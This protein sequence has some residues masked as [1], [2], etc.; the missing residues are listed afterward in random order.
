MPH[1]CAAECVCRH[2]LDAAAAALAEASQLLY[3]SIL[4]GSDESIET[5]YA[6]FRAA[7][8][9]FCGARAAYLDHRQNYDPIAA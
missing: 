6:S 2:D 1:K 8:A 7:R 9:K 3:N 4:A 5:C